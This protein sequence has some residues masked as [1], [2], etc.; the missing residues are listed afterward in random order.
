MW[1]RSQKEQLLGWLGEYDGPGAYAR[2]NPGRDARFFYN[3]LRCVEGLIWRAEALGED[4]QL[5]TRGDRRSE[6]R[7][8]QPV[9]PNVARSLAWSSGTESPNS[10]TGTANSVRA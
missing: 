1:Y 5:L 9:E 2:K 7:G 3:D 6:G 8:S 10:S 4:P